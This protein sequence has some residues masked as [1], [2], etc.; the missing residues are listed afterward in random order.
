MYLSLC[1]CTEYDC[2]LSLLFSLHSDLL[3][4]INHHFLAV[5]V[6]CQTLIR[7]HSQAELSYMKSTAGPF[8]LLYFVIA[9]CYHEDLKFIIFKGSVPKLGKAQVGGKQQWQ[10]GW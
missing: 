6:C 5:C 9:F 2:I 4:S 7:Q 3:N 1:K 10:D 8:H